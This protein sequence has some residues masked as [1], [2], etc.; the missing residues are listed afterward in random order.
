MTDRP[1]ATPRHVSDILTDLSDDGS[2]LSQDARGAIR[3]GLQDPHRGC[4]CP[5]C[6]R[7]YLRA[8]EG[9]P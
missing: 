3:A 8:V 6:M 5:D 4:P 9:R 1:A 7:A 2:P